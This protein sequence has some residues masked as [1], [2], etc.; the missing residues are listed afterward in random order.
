MC[1]VN[2]LRVW[3]FHNYAPDLKARVLE[4]FSLAD[5]LDWLSCFTHKDALK[6]RLLDAFAYM[7]IKTQVKRLNEKL[8]IRYKGLRKQS[9]D[10]TTAVIPNSHYEPYDDEDKDSDDG[11]VV[12]NTAP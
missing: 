1:R 6:Q 11:T 8:K 12:S 9:S 2:F 7:M 3:V 5:S 4:S 10:A